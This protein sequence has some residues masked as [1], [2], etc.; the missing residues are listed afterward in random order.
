[1]NNW[2]K[3]ILIRLLHGDQWNA[4]VI[5]LFARYINV[6]IKSIKVELSFSMFEPFRPGQSV[7]KIIFYRI[8]TLKTVVWCY[9][10]DFI[11]FEFEFWQIRKLLS[12]FA[13]VLVNR[14]FNDFHKAPLINT[15]VKM[16]R[17]PP[18]GRW[19]TLSKLPIL[20][21]T[22]V[23]FFIRFGRRVYSP[24]SWSYSRDTPAPSRLGP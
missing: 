4:F 11:S 16:A 17:V 18:L 20:D 14:K 8:T 9:Y 12:S 19:W 13:S 24:A 15:H 6:K 22:L 10:S 7:T 1:M 23:G 3:C 2:T 21:L 5:V